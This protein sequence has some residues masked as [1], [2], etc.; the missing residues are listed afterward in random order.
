MHIVII[1]IILINNFT[2]TNNN[3]VNECVDGELE[4]E[5]KKRRGKD[6]HFVPRAKFFFNI[7][8]SPREIYYSQEQKNKNRKY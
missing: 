4:K 6:E 2:G 5:S 7:Y 3:K 8:L 1:I